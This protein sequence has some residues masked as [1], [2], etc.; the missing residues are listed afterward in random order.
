MIGESNRRTRILLIDDDSSDARLTREAFKDSK[1]GSDIEVVSDGV[2]AL[3]FLRREGRYKNA[4]QPDII[5]LDLRLPRKGG[6]EVLAEI[7]ADD[8]LKLIP[9]VIL[10][11]SKAEEDIVRSYNL[12][13]NAYILKPMNLQQFITMVKSIKGFWGEIVT[14]P[15][16]QKE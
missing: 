15:P 10:S 14:L 4:L 13:A 11:N 16:S 2:E 3:A 1:L 5:L 8:A 12:Y 7:K 9:V 6:L